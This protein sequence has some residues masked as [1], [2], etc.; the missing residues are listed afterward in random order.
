MS[1]NAKVPNSYFQRGGGLVE[2]NFQLLMPSPDLLKSKK[3]L[4]GGL[5]KIF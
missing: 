5:L 3:N 2:T 4:Q 1:K